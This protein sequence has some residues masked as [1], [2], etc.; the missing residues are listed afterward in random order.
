MFDRTSFSISPALI[1]SAFVS[2]D[3]FIHFTDAHIL[4]Y[5][6]PAAQFKSVQKL[7]LFDFVKFFP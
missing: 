3:W 2:T 1:L 6:L 4:S 5:R 7:F